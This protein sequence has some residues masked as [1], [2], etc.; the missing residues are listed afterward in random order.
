MLSIYTKKK[1]Q[2]LKFIFDFYKLR[3][4]FFV[5]LIITKKVFIYRFLITNIT[6]HNDRLLRFFF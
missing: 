4:F 6:Q 2:I 3:T 5:S 1:F